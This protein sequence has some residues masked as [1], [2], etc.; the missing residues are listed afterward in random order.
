ML[1]DVLHDHVIICMYIA[2]LRAYVQKMCMHAHS[3]FI[4]VGNANTLIIIKQNKKCCKCVVCMY[5]CTGLSV[6]AKPPSSLHSDCCPRHTACC[7]TTLR[8]GLWIPVYAVKLTKS[9]DTLIFE[10]SLP[11]EKGHQTI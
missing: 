4:F 9:R 6:F 11:S 3:H 8:S 10:H 1:L 7:Q 5:V 2:V